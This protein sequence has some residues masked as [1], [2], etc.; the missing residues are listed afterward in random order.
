MDFWDIHDR[1]VAVCEGMKI[2]KQRICRPLDKIQSYDYSNNDHVHFCIAAHLLNEEDF[3]AV[4]PHG[5]N[6]EFFRVGTDNKCDYCKYAS[7]LDFNKSDDG[8]KSIK[9]WLHDEVADK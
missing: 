6:I 7:V 5:G 8:K 9:I 2:A 1:W 3:K 4:C